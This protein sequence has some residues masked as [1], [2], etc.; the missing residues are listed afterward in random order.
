MGVAAQQFAAE[1][2]AVRAAAGV[3][4]QQSAAEAVSRAR[5][6]GGAEEAARGLRVGLKEAELRSKQ[7]AEQV[8]MSMVQ[9][10]GVRSAE[11]RAARRANK[12]GAKWHEGQRFGGHHQAEQGAGRARVQSTE[13]H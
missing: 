6:L 11:S 10:C 1:L 8:G 4:A 3:A 12:Q 9:G 7:A 2:E 5:E 13:W